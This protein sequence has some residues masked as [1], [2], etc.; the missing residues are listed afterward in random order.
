[1]SDSRTLLIVD[2]S[3]EDREV[4]RDFLAD[5]PQISYRFVE[6]P[7]GEV[8]LDLFKQQP[9]DAILLDFTCQI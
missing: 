7:L 5:D 1:M 6:A 2:D 8:A 4:Y 9:C 3:P